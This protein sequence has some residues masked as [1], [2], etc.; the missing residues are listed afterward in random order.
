MEMI[1]SEATVDAPRRSTRSSGLLAAG[2]G[3]ALL[4]HALVAAAV[5]FVIWRMGGYSD[6]DLEAGGRFAVN[7]EAVR[8]FV[9]AHAAL[10]LTIL[11]A[12]LGLAFFRRWLSLGLLVGWAGGWLLNAVA[13]RLDMA[14]W[15]PPL[16]QGDGLT[17]IWQW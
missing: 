5:P 6:V 12:S 11:V 2:V 15:W 7:F 13:V 9:L 16:L 8:T 4:G 3:T 17:R 14:V 10:G 1:V